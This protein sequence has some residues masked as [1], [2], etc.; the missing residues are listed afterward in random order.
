MILNVTASIIVEKSKNTIFFNLDI[1]NLDIDTI[2]KSI[3][4]RLKIDNNKYTFLRD[5]ILP[6]KDIKKNIKYWVEL[7]EKNNN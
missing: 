1:E 7:I 3:L 2:K 4:E 6:E 5:G